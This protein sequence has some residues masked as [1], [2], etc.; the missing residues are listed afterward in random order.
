MFRTDAFLTS[1]DAHVVALT[2]ERDRPAVILDRTAFYPSAGGQ[3]HDTG[4]LTDAS[5]ADAAGMTVIDVVERK[6]GVIAHVFETDPGFAVGAAL[7]GAIHWPRRFDH[8]QQHSGQHVLSRA[9]IETAGLDTIAVHIGA[10][11]CTLDLPAHVTQ[12]QL[13]AAED[14]ANRAIHDNIAIRD[15]EVGDADLARIPLRKPPKVS[16][17]I[18]I[19][20][21]DGYD[22]SACGGTHVRACGQIGQIKIVRSEKRGA[23][24]RVTFICGRRAL[25]DYRRTLRDTSQ[26]AES[27]TVARHELSGAI[28]RLRADA[29]ATARRLAQAQSA[30]LAHETRA[31]LDEHA[32]D[33]DGRRIIARVWDGRDADAIRQLAKALTA[34]A[35]VIA[36]LGATGERSALCFARAPDVENVDAGAL[37][38]RA[39]TTLPGA[40]GGGSRE[41]AQGGGPPTDADTLQAAIAAARHG[42]ATE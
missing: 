5:I 8:M 26:L 30:L 16:G 7:R 34:H 32:P 20:E 36:L 14:E 12:T 2:T 25:E 6:D 9:F 27:L 23:E 1:F 31:L 28:E 29:A 33:A 42:L 37:F 40:K 17:R 35:G 39:L 19:V 24:T 15:Y 4:A 22:W 11:V 10:D 21:I 3:P 18:R 13:D 41:L 38:K